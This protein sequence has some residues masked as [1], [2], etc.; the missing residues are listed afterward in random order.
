MNL[1]NIQCSRCTQDNLNVLFGDSY[2]QTVNSRGE[3]V[4]QR[5]QVYN[6]TAIDLNSTVKIKTNKGLD[7]VTK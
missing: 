7:A 2:N 3:G 4:Q 5:L 1:C 6:Q